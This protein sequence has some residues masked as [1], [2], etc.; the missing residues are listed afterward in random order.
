MTE[1]YDL[2]GGAPPS[3]KH[4]ATSVSAA[5]EIEPSVGRLQALVLAELKTNGPGTDEELMERTGLAPNTLRPRRREL[6]LK[7]LVGDSGRRKP[8]KSGRAAVLW[9]NKKRS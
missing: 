8:T 2:F 3:V 4:S 5:E 9:E 7:G 6:Q 1:T